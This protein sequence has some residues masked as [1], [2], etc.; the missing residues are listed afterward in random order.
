MSNVNICIFVVNLESG[1]ICGAPSEHSFL[2]RTDPHNEDEQKRAR[3]ETVDF[4]HA[5]W[6]EHLRLRK[7]GELA[8]VRTD[9][10]K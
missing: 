3:T 1:E 9:L 8:W 4:C 5:H 6:E 10:K 7:K 2:S